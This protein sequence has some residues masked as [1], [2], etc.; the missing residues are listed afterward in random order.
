MTLTLPPDVQLQ[1]GTIE[2][3]GKAKKMFIDGK[4]VDSMS[5]ETF[6]TYNPATGEVLAEI[7]LADAEDVDRAVR[8]ARAAV[9]H[10]PWSKMSGAQRGKLLW[11]IAELIDQ[12]A[13]ELDRKSVV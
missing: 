5:G 13:D 4:W 10:G 7:P 8:A 2:F 1:A 9:E 11:K 3:L 6:P 12:Y